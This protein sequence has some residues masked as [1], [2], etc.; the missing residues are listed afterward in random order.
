MIPVAS[1][2]MLKS[3]IFRRKKQKLKGRMIDELDNI[4]KEAVVAYSKY[5]PRNLSGGLKK[6][7]KT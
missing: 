6:P 1:G 7:T 4:W 5:Y 2:L 3:S